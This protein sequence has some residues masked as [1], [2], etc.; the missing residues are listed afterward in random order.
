MAANK[1]LLLGAAA[2]GAYYLYSTMKGTPVYKNASGQPVTEIACGNSVSFDVQGY[3]RVWLDQ[4]KDGVL[5]YSGIFPQH[6]PALPMP[7]HVLNCAT[8]IGVYDVAVY[9]LIED[10]L[11]IHKGELIGQTR[12][13]VRPQSTV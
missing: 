4:L 1:G 3:E 6:Q 12:L 5:N 10:G 2:V 8:D 9:E 13:T 11:T 7:L